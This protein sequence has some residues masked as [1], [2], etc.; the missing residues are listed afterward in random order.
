MLEERAVAPLGATRARPVDVRLL[1]A[2]QMPLRD[3]VDRGSFRGD[4][5]ARLAGATLALP[6][7]VERREEIPRLFARC[8][9]DAGG[10][11]GRLQPT[12]VEKLCLLEW[13]FNARQ[14]LAALDGLLPPAP[15]SPGET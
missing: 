14:L 3:C 12:L 4:L 5:L 8:F 15:R 13:P 9:A 7:L 6:G 10:D 2:S 1:A 11:V